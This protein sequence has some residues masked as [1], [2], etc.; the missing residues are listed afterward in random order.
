MRLLLSRNTWL[1]SRVKCRVPAKAHEPRLEP[2]WL[3][4]QVG[5]DPE[6]TR[7]ES[8]GVLREQALQLG[9]KKRKPVQHQN[10]QK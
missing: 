10:E 9:E 1:Q 2:R 8:A 5:S 3:S 6:M 4:W 7:P